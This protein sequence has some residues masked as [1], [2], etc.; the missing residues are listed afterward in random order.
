M[1]RGLRKREKMYKKIIRN[2]VA[3]TFISAGVILANH[4]VAIFQQNEYK[5]QQEELK[6]RIY[7]ETGILPLDEEEIGNTDEADTYAIS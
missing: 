2:L 6:D 3:V 4:M 1:K 5:S 7:K